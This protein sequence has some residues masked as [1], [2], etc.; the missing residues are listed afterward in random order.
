MALFQSQGHNHTHRFG[1]FLYDSS[2]SAEQQHPGIHKCFRALK[3]KSSL[4]KKLQLRDRNHLQ[5]LSGGFSLCS[6]GSVFSDSPTSHSCLINCLFM[7][8]MKPKLVKQA[9]CCMKRPSLNK[10]RHTRTAS[11]ASGGSTLCS[12]VGSGSF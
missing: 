8:E 4:L 5:L 9:F 1:C 10:Q 12:G 11:A 2:G 7:W 3:L 6:T